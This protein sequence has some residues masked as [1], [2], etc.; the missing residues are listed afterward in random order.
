MLGRQRRVQVGR[1]HR[2]RRGVG[3]VLDESL[4]ASYY[5][6]STLL[7]CIEAKTH[8]AHMTLLGL[9]GPQPNTEAA[10]GLFKEAAAAGCSFASHHLGVLLASSGAS[11]AAAAHLEVALSGGAPAAAVALQGLPLQPS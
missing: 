5:G 10:K 2:D 11:G 8:L 3:V 9:G 4:A 1:E 6:R 7:G